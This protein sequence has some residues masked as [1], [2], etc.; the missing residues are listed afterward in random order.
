MAKKMP[1]QE[2]IEKFKRRA[3]FMLVP[4]NID[5]CE[6]EDMAFD[7]DCCG[8]S[9]RKGYNIKDCNG[10]DCKVGKD[11]FSSYVMQRLAT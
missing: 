6:F 11:C 2:K 9:G 7:C 1:N 3:P 5:A 4:D 10:N 8:G